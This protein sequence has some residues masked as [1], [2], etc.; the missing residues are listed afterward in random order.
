M[1]ELAELAELAAVLGLEWL[2]RELTAG[3]GEPLAA[4]GGWMGDFKIGL[5]GLQ[6][7]RGT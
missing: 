7:P 6:K 2:E 5:F 4:I 3:P 1:A